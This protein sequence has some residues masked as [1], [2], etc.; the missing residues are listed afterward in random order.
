MADDSGLTATTG[1]TSL[2]DSSIFD[3]KVTETS[4]EN[5]FIGPTSYVEEE[6]PQI[7]TRVILVQEAAEQEEL[8]N[9]L[10]S[11]WSTS[12]IKL[13]TKRRAFAIFMSST[14]LY[15]HDEPSTVFYWIQEEGRTS[16]I[17][18]VGSSYGWSY[19]KRL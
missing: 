9:A 5:L 2:A 6:M 10:K 18:D 3:S 12:C 8:I 15:K 19:S 4:K 1:R 16:Q 13:C 17:G 7:E 11:H 14:L